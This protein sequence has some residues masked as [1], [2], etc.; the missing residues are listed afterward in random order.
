MLGTSASFVGYFT[1]ETTIT[2]TW[3]VVVVVVVSG[4]FV[5]FM[6]NLKALL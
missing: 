2:D 5:P 1:L 4:S 3:T 6:H